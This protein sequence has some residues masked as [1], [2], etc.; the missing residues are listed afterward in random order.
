MIKTP[1]VAVSGG[2]DPAHIGHYLML[3]KA[4]TF[5]DVV[6]MLNSDE[7]LLRKKGYVFMPFEERKYIL[8]CCKFV[9]KVVAIDDS[10]DTACKGLIALRPDYFAN[11]GDRESGNT[12]EGAVCREFDIEM[13]WGVGGGKIQSSSDLVKNSAKMSN[14]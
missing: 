14:K 8:E 1:I 5:G 7:W 6:V 2:L 12:P 3:E 11:G 9:H 10:D 13:L 4:S